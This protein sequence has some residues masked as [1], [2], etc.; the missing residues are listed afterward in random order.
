MG[1]EEVWRRKSD[2]ELRKAAGSLREYTDEGR[3]IILAELSRRSISVDVADLTPSLHAED[4]LN[5]PVHRYQD[6]YRVAKSVV[7]IGNITKFLGFGFGILVFVAAL[8]QE[9]GGLVMLGASFVGALVG[10]GFWVAGVF[11]AAHGQLLQA[12]L[13]TAVHSS[14]FL[15]NR[16]RALA[17]SLSV[18]AA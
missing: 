11:V 9:P 16:Q 14:P 4:D 2:D 17:M 12:T 1:A 8:T 6:A 3:K 10:L 5:S 13:D 15:T 7:V 18:T